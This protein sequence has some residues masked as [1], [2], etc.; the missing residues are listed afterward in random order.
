LSERGRRAFSGTAREGLGRILKQRRLMREL[1]LV[2]LARLSGV[3]P[4]YLAR[5]ERG[6]RYPSAKILRRIAEPLGFSVS[7]VLSLAG[8]LPGEADKER[9]SWVRE[10]DPMVAMALSQEPVEVQRAALAI[11]NIIR[12]M[13]RGCTQGEPSRV[14][15]ER[16]S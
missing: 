12:A 11:V 3:S 13:A 8:F 15:G 14:E 9:A 6:Q 7:E 2:E 5:V 16:G 10:L 1:T 4:S